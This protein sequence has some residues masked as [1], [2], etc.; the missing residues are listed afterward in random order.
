MGKEERSHKR[1]CHRCCKDRVKEMG[2]EK[3]KSKKCREIIGG[4]KKK[5]KGNGRNASMI[6]SVLVIVV[7]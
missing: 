6:E 5:R 1:G 3:K 7:A 4:S 2:L